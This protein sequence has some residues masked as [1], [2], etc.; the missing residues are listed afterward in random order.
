MKNHMTVK[1]ATLMAGIPVYGT[2]AAAFQ[3]RSF[4]LAHFFLCS[5]H[6]TFGEFVRVVCIL[7]R[8]NAIIFLPYLANAV[9]LSTYTFTSAA[10]CC[11]PQMP[12][13]HY[14]L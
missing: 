6:P 8:Q 2:C 11:S 5:C 9:I 13:F 10:L 12:G 14:K 4:P 3:R 1:T 7:T